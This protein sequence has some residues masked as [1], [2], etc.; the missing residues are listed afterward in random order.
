MCPFCWD[1]VRGNDRGQYRA[2]VGEI[3]HP[4]DWRACH[5]TCARQAQDRGAKITVRWMIAKS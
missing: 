4:A 1:R 2:I 3:D 5:I